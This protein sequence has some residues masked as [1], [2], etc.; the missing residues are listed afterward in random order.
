MNNTFFKNIL[1]GF[2][3]DIITQYDGCE[4][5]DKY[6]MNKFENGTWYVKERNDNYSEMIYKTLDISDLAAEI[7]IL[8]EGII[9][10]EHPIMFSGG[11]DKNNII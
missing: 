9:K 8:V 5:K 11:F 4:I 3:S 1:L 10:S 6:G 7:E 2:I